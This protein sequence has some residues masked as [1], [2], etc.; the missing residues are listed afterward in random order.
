MA[1]IDTQNIKRRTNEMIGYSMYKREIEMKQKRIKNLICV[2]GIFTFFIAGTITVNA[3]TNNA[4]VDKIKE[5]LTFNVDEE[6]PTDCKTLDDGT[7]ICYYHI[8]EE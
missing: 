6:H 3:L 8:D 5:V 4:I 1:K 7:R 2:F